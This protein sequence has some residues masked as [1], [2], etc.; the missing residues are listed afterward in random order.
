MN[1]G[2]F[3]Y[4]MQFVDGNRID[5]T[6]Y[7]LDKLDQ[8]QRESLSAL[9]LD[10]DQRFGT[11]PLPSENDYLPTPPTAKRF[12]DCCNEFWW[13]STY[14]AKGLARR[15]LPYAKYM[16]DVVV[17]EQ[18][19]KMLMWQVGGQSHYT[20]IAGK[21]GKHLEHTLSPA[22]WAML[23]QTYADAE[24]GSLPYGR[25]RMLEIARDQSGQQTQAE[26]MVAI[27]RARRFDL[28]VR[29]ANALGVEE[30]DG[31]SGLHLPEFRFAATGEQAAPFGF[32]YARTEPRG[33]QH[34]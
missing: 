10:K 12:A 14:V 1:D 30:G 11:L 7:P 5:L 27:R 28:G 6:L 32:E 2:H 8:Y 29:A 31:I 33:E 20:R 23:A 4:L 15:E 25:Q 24:A 3:A 16:L 26:R 13:V 18:L 22:H 19:M 17:R 9:L 34:L 21:F